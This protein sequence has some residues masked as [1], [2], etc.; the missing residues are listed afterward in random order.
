MYVTNLEVCN[1]D[2]GGSIQP[3]F[4]IMADTN[5]WKLCQQMEVLCVG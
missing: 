1:I 5:C 4:M 3:H 2:D